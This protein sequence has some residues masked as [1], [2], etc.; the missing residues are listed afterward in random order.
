MHFSNKA[1]AH[2]ILARNIN[3]RGEVVQHFVFLVVRFDVVILQK[4]RNL[5][6]KIFE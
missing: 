3:N 4:P 5:A 1:I 2:Q 6:N